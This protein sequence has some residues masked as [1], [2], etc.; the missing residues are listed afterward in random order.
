M[1]LVS[2]ARPGSLLPDAVIRVRV[3]EAELHYT[4]L[5]CEHTAGLDGDAAK[6]VGEAVLKF[7]KQA[8][9]SLERDLLAKAN[10]AIVK[11]ADTREVRIELDKLLTG[12]VPTIQRKK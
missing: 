3:T 9:P 8:K 11:A 12:K 5:V 2:P 6:K 10:A 4:D 7:L 1:P